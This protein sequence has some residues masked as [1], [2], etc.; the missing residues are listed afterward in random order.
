MNRRRSGALGEDMACAYL[1]NQGFKILDRNYA[2]PTGEIDIIAREGDVIAFVEV[3]ARTSVRYG[4]P[5][6]A[7][8][9]AKQAH[10]LRTALLYIAE[11]GLDDAPMRF[12]IVEV[13]PEEIH[14]I[15]AAF[16]GSEWNA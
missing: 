10:I 12:D 7:V 4:T 15:R 13:L 1:K 5:A 3:K 2:R 9:R 16:D 8:N 6:E 14:L 11:R